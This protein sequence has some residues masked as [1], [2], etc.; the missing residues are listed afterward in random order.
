MA[1]DLAGRR[2]DGLGEAQPRQEPGCFRFAL[3]AI[4][5]EGGTLGS[6]LRSAESINEQ[7]LIIIPTVLRKVR[8]GNGNCS[9]L[10]GPCWRHA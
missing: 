3:R 1:E 7:H 9:K 10:P 4:P 5:A 8:A 2:L 6:V